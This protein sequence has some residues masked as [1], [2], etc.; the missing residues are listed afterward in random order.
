VIDRAGS[1]RP[2]FGGSANRKAYRAIA[3]ALAKRELEG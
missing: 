1:G 3:H 2:G